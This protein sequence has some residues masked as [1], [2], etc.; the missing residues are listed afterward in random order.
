MTNVLTVDNVWL[1]LDN[2]H[3]PSLSSAPSSKISHRL[4]YVYR[5][6]QN[7]VAPVKFFT[8]FSTTVWSFIWKFCRFIF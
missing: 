4:L 6:W 5:V 1:S 2:L 7:T 3:A 8:V